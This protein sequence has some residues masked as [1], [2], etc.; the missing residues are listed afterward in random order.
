MF[1]RHRNFP[2]CEEDLTEK[3]KLSNEQ[4]TVENHMRIN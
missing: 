1:S 2:T 4:K 3:K